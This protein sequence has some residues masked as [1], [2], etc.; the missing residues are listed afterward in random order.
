MQ[1]TRK[2]LVAFALTLA[3]SAV[4]LAQYVGSRHSDKYHYRSCS[5]ARRIKPANLVTFK[6][7]RQAENAGYYACKICRPP[8]AD[9]EKR[10]P[11]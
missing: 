3:L 7:A 1:Y 10:Q 6:N 2:A 11:R 8:S 4:V 5:S 9:D